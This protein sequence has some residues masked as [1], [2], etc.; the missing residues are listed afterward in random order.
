M[1][2]IRR[3]PLLLW[4]DGYERGLG[5]SRRHFTDDLDGIWW[6]KSSRRQFVLGRRRFLVGRLRKR[7]LSPLD[8][9]QIVRWEL[10]RERPDGA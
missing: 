10:G 7:V 8:V 3:G 2:L 1:R 5:L 6:E 4:G 9:Q